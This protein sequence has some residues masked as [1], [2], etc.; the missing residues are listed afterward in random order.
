M[1]W[2]GSPEWRALAV[3]AFHVRKVAVY[4][5]LLLAWQLASAWRDGAGP[6]DMAYL[7]GWTAGLGAAAVGILCMLAYLYARGTIYTLTNRRIVDPH[8]AGPAGDR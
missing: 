5:A 3:A 2:Q 6:A 7:S 8:R 4:F 1:L